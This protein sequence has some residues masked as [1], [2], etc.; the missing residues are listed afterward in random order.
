MLSIDPADLESAMQARDRAAALYLFDP[1]V[2]L[3]DVGLRIIERDDNRIT[4]QPTVRVH[5][6]TKP[7][8]AEFEAFRAAHPQRIVDKQLVGFDVDIVQADYRLQ[9]YWY[10]LRP[11]DPRAQVHDPLCGG[12]SISNEWSYGYGTLGGLVKDRDTLPDDAI[13]VRVFLVEVSFPEK[14]FIEHA[15]DVGPRNRPDYSLLA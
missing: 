13:Q 8:G 7:R 4:A 5:R 9:R 3:I 12:V 1:D 10:T 15:Q 2:S 14:L 11:Y 6:R